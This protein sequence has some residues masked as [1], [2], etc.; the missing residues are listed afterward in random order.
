MFDE[1]NIFFQALQF[2]GPGIDVL[3]LFSFVTEV[4]DELA[5]AFMH[6]HNCS[7]YSNY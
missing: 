1:K 7:A 4:K 5:V 3:K 2:L 6:P